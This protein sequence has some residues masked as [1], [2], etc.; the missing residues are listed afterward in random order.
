MNKSIQICG[1]LILKTV[2]LLSINSTP[3]III[4]YCKLLVK[5]ILRKGFH[6][7]TNVFNNTIKVLLKNSFVRVNIIE[8][9]LLNK[10]IFNNVFKSLI[11]SVNIK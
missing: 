3:E 11:I 7:V 10:F 2:A 8:K 9:L 4:Q 5:L 1:D 6:L